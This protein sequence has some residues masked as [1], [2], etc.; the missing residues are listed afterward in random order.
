MAVER[1]RPERDEASQVQGKCASVITG[2]HSTKR[3]Q[4]NDRRKYRRSR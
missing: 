4:C 3:P 1:P 2:G